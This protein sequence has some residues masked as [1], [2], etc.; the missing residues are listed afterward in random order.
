MFTPT[1][2]EIVHD[3]MQFVKLE[4][5]LVIISHTPLILQMGNLISYE[6]YIQWQSWE[7]NSDIYTCFLY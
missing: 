5:I 7:Q 3:V 2:D 1:G 4:R 6:L